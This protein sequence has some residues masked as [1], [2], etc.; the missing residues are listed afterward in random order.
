MLRTFQETC[1]TALTSARPCGASEV[2]SEARFHGEPHHGLLAGPQ[3]ADGAGEALESQAAHATVRGDGEPRVCDDVLELQGQ[4]VEQVTVVG[5]ELK[6][7]Q[8]GTLVITQGE[9]HGASHPVGSTPMNRDRYS[10]IVSWL[11]TE[12]S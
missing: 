7:K 5:G 4:A 2:G 9:A 1:R 6:E 3:Q 8:G 11:T 10:L 12:K